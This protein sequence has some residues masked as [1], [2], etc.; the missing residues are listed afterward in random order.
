MAQPVGLR[1]KCCKHIFVHI[2]VLTT[3]YYIFVC[4]CSL[5]KHFT[6]MWNR[7]MQ[8]GCHRRIRHRYT[9]SISVPLP[10]SVGECQLLA[11]RIHTFSYV[12]WCSLN[13]LKYFGIKVKYFQLNVLTFVATCSCV[14]E[15]WETIK[16]LFSCYIFLCLQAYLSSVKLSLGIF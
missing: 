10:S 3:L 12:Y 11:I 9:P 1:L 6:K 14:V 13:D 4:V 8:V 5:R 7:C 15:M 2:T 16:A